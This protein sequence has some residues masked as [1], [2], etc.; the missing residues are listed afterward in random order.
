MGA[1]AQVSAAAAAA[2]AAPFASRT[3]PSSGPETRQVQPRGR[4]KPPRPQPESGSGGAPEEQPR[5]PPGHQPRPWAIQA[6]PTCGVSL[7]APRSCPR[8]RFASEV[9]EP[10][11]VPPPISVASHKHRFPRQ[12]QSPDSPAAFRTPELP[13]PS[14]KMA[15]EASAC[16]TGNMADET[17]S[18]SRDG[19]AHRDSESRATLLLNV[20]PP[21]LLERRKWK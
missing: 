2:A 10:R 1:S 7:P 3:R 13:L 5:P 8:Q 6:P 11:S 9:P 12:K 17:R 4:P 18:F 19:L 20:F 21:T 16:T 15:H 14:A